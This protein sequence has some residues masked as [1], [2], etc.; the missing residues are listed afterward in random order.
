MDNTLSGG[1]KEALK[2]NLF[3]QYATWVAFLYTNG[4][5]IVLLEKIPDD[6][7]AVFNQ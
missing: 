3:Y 4:L 7:T 5:T 1:N 6:I 2:T